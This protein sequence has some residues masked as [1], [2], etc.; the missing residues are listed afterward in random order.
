MEDFEPA[1][2]PRT[3]MERRAFLQRAAVVSGAT[4]WAAPTVQSIMTPAFAVGSGLCPPGHLVRFKYDVSNNR[5]DSGSGGG[6][7]WCLPDGY[8][9]ADVSVSG[10]GNSALF[11]VAGSTYSITVTLADG[12]KTAYVKIPATSRIEDLQAKAGDMVSG[13]CDDFESQTG[14]TAVVSLGRKRISFVVGVICV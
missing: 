5:F 8:G 1:D 2:E 13:A 6:V 9:D 3:G 11:T 10:T 7:Q 4:L 12:G 14:D